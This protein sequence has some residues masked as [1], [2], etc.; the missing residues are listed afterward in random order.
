MLLGRPAVVCRRDYTLEAWARCVEI[1][2]SQRILS[3][4]LRRDPS[5][6]Y[7]KPLHLIGRTRSGDIRAVLVPRWNFSHVRLSCKKACIKPRHAR[8]LIQRRNLPA[9]SCE[10]LAM[11]HFSRTRS[12]SARIEVARTLGLTCIFKYDIT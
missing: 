7:A 6:R 5:A 1:T 4:D 11:S 12:V 9:D 10:H 3:W 8:R 2:L